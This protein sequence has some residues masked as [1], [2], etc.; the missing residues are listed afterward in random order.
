MVLFRGFSIRWMFQA[1]QHKWRWC[2][3][4]G[5]SCLNH[6]G[7]A[8]PRLRSP[9]EGRCS[10]RNRSSAVAISP[11][12]ERLCEAPTTIGDA[13]HDVRV[14]GLLMPTI[15]PS[16]PT[17]PDDPPVIDDQH[18]GDHQV[19]APP[20]CVA[21]PGQPSRSTL[22]GPYLFCRRKPRSFHLDD[23]AGIGEANAI[24]GQPGTSRGTGGRC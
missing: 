15:F 7:D 3:W 9:V 22:P 17:S 16:N 24:A 14:V 6:R 23:Q 4:P 5:R 2:R 13:I 12:R 8:G 1:P 10:G 11:F 19:R 21:D 18:I 20:S